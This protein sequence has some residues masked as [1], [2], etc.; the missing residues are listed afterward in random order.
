M[1][2]YTEAAASFGHAIRLLTPFLQTQPEAFIQ[3]A[4]NFYNDYLDSIKRA[5]G[6][7]DMA[8]LAPLLEILDTRKQNRSTD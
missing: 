5:G 2:R 3:F 7:P 4:S 8:L 6:Q 1:R